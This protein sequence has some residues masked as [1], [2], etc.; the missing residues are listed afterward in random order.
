MGKGEMPPPHPLQPMVGRRPGPRV[1]RV[2][3]LC[4][5]LP[6]CGTWK[7]RYLAPDLGSKVELALDVGVVGEL[8]LRV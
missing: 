7:C 4:L 2:G 1:I 8:D 3:E 6:Y 5:P